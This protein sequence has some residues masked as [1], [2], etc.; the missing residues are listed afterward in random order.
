M[1][2]DNPSFIQKIKNHGVVVLNIDWTIRNKDTLKFMKKYGRS[3]LHF[4]IVF[5]PL[6]PDGLILPE[7][8]SEHELNS[9]LD[10]ISVTPLNP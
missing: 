7:I 8:L 4:Y 9:I 6:I 5:S 3:G 1:V 2:L 10:N